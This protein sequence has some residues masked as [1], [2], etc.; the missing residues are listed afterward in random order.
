MYIW[1]GIENDERKA[2]SEKENGGSVWRGVMK[3]EAAII[4]E[5]RKRM[6]GGSSVMAS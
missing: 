3:S 4:S 5:K 6:C 2:K 1:H